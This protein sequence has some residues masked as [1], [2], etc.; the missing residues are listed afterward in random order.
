[1]GAYDSTSEQVTMLDVD[2]EQL[3][4]YQVSFDAFYKGLACDYHHVFEA[5]GYGSGGYV[6][7]HIR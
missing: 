3:K 1:M 7:I 4:P 2:P 5:F 6:Y